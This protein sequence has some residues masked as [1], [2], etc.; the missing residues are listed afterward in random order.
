MLSS[1]HCG[2]GTAFALEGYGLVTCAHCIAN[3]LVIA[4]KPG[5][6]AEQHGVT[7][8]HRDDH[9]DLAILQIEPPLLAALRRGDDASAQQD[10][11]AIVAGYGN[12]AKG[13]GSRLIKGHVTGRGVR[14]GVDVIFSDHRAFGGNSG[15]P[16]LDSE[17][18]V[19]GVL[20]RAVSVDTP[21]QETTILPISL[22]H[23]ISPV[24]PT[25]PS[26][27]PKGES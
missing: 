6:I 1:T 24:K 25:D 26:E 9:R 7:I 5:P 17:L 14:H 2:T 15:G 3:G 16:V 27:N 18:R 10:D 19:I 23:S 4:V 22:L 13:S 8:T 21:G 12:Y 11:A 20:Q